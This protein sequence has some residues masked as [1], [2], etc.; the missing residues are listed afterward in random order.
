[1]AS[2]DSTCGWI[3]PCDL[4]VDDQGNAHLLWTERALDERLRDRFF[5]EERQTIALNTAVVRGGRVIS[6]KSL[7]VGGEGAS[8]EIPGGGRFHVTG[9]GRL[10][11]IYYVSGASPAGDAVSENRALEIQNGGIRQMHSTG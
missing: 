3:S 8:S 4:W 9:D 7:H 11:V 1:M 10:L 6:R 2:R 5:P